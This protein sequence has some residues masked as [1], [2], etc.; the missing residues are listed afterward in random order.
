MEGSFRKLFMETL[1]K[2]YE[3]L[4]KKYGYSP[5]SLG[6]EKGKQFLRFHQLTCDFE[7]KNASILDVGCGFGDFIKYLNLNKIKNFKFYFNRF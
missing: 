5:K 6:W 7:L 1:N 4:Y 2:Y 3:K